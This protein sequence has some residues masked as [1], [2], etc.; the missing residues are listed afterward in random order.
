MSNSTRITFTIENANMRFR[1]SFSS[2][3]K[4][5]NPSINDFPNFFNAVRQFRSVGE[6]LEHLRCFPIMLSTNVNIAYLVA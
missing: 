1:G 6:G 3:I 2:V 4:P 5:T